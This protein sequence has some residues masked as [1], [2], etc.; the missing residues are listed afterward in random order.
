MRRLSLGASLAAIVL[1]GLLATPTWA[2]PIRAAPIRAAFAETAVAYANE[3]APAY[4]IFFSEGPARLSDVASE[5]IEMAAADADRGA[6]LVRLVG[7]AEYAAAVKDELVRYGVAAHAI[8]VMARKALPALGA[9]MDE[10]ATVDI[11]VEPATAVA[12][13]ALPS[14]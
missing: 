5:T 9:S 3:A 2:A 4:V 8:R 11:Y 14:G 12:R 10:P 1:G 7:P 13:Q 6:G